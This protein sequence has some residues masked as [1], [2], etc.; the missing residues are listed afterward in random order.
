MVPQSELGCICFKLP[1]FGAILLFQ[2]V[3][4]GL[5]WFW[6]V[7][8]VLF[9]RGGSGLTLRR[10]GFREVSE[11]VIRFCYYVRRERVEFQSY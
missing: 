9:E 7:W 5:D 2:I 4:V 6:V 10:E 1:Y 11:S 3:W 8:E